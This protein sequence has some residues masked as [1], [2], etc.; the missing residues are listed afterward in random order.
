[1]I[2][3]YWENRRQYI[4][5]LLLF[6]LVIIP[7]IAGTVA[8]A[9]RSGLFHAHAGPVT[10]DQLKVFWTF[11]GVAVAAAVSLTGY[12]MTSNQHRTSEQRLALDTTVSGLKLLANQE[13]SGYAPKAV[14]A[15]ALATLIYLRQ[16][17]IAMRSLSTAWKEEAI[18]SPSAV[19][20]ISEIVATADDMTQLEAALLL[21]CTCRF[22]VW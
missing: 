13:G 17:I 3:R 1:M 18:D 16:P 14:V 4:P 10:N 7:T 5:W 8:L 19:W 15:G 11:A 6:V 2:T 21:K 12:L 20:L 22:A 9:I